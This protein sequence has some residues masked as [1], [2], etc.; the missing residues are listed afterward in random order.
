MPTRLE[1][2]ITRAEARMTEQRAKAESQRQLVLAQLEAQRLIE[3]ETKVQLRAAE[4]MAEEAELRARAKEQE[5][6][7]ANAEAKRAELDSQVAA[8]AGEGQAVQDK[9]MRLRAGMATASEDL[10]RAKLQNDLKA[11]A[12]LSGDGGGDVSGVRFDDVFAER[13][14]F[15]TSTRRFAMHCRA[16]QREQR[17]RTRVAGRRQQDA[18]FI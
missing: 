3:L 11:A 13:R 7:L 12:A 8:L 16:S 18:R 15:L 4:R 17:A 5:K 14:D 10:N 6:E 2:A 9:L 1:A